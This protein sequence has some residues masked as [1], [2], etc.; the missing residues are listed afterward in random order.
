MN[1]KDDL[2]KELKKKKR[3][4]DE[5]KQHANKTLKRE[6]TKIS[7]EKEHKLEEEDKKLSKELNHLR[8]KRKSALDKIES[9]FKKITKLFDRKAKDAVSEKE[10]E[11]KKI[12]R[13]AKHAN[14]VVE[15][16]TSK[17]VEHAK[18]DLIKT[19]KRVYSRREKILNTLQFIAVIYLFI[20]SIIV[21]KEV[22]IALSAG[23]IETITSTVDSG[24]SAFGAGWLS[25][26]LAQSASVIAILANSLVGASIINFTTAFYIL[27]GLTLGNSL[28]PVLASL[29]IK[30]DHHWKLRHGFELGLANIIYSV[31]LVIIIL[32]I[33][34]PTQIFTSSGDK[35]A[36]WAETLPAFKSV[37]DLLSVITDPLLNLVRFEHWPLAV[38]FLA[39]VAL[40]I[41]SLS[42]V[43]KSMFVFLGGKRHT[44]AIM[45]KYLSTHWR[46]FG[47]GLGL[48]IIIPSAS[49][50]TTLLVPLAIARIVK[51]RQAIPYMIGTSVGTFID[52][53]M[54]S[55]ANAQGH[56]VAGG[57]V[58]TMMSALGI[59]FIFGNFG[60]NVIYKVTRY[61]SLRVIKM[62]KRNI[63][64]Y[65]A[66]FVLIPALIIIIF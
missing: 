56:A 22:A 38:S 16:L 65:L 2:K 9:R 18:K 49:L 52:V 41:F 39:G 35:I 44:R 7:H 20:L 27:L 66:G 19:K 11:H 28:T 4:F 58:L 45:E 32:I 59:L 47:I 30:T 53:L 15:E 50:L 51:L 6:K 29:V 61:L 55:F 24:A 64:K 12:H 13:E 8:G 1:D 48:T 10:K 17:E 42:K 57:V 43:G 31:F 5:A 37:P 62:R 33:Q 60:S 40:L 14:H 26:M 46:A 21:I 63:L 36:E 34:I 54:A 25:S 23:T 3:E